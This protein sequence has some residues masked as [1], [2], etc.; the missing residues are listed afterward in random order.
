[1]FSTF[2]RQFTGRVDIVLSTFGFKKGDGEIS[3]RVRDVIVWS[4]GWST[5]D[6]VMYY[7]H[8]SKVRCKVCFQFELNFPK[9]NRKVCV[10]C[11]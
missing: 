2:Y 8:K 3:T 10:K 4:H 6:R 7:V 11:L 9:E 5:F 1:M